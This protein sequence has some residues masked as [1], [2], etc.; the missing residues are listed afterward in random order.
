MTSI[1][2]LP[3]PLPLYI[4]MQLSDLKSLDALRRSSSL[5]AAVFAQHAVELLEQ[6]MLLT[7][8]EGV[9]IR[10][11]GYILLL[12]YRSRWKQTEN[13]TESLYESASTPLP[14]DTPTEAIS[15]AL[16]AFSYLH[17]LWTSIAMEKLAQLY[18]LPHRHSKEVPYL[19]EHYYSADYITYKVPAVS[20]LYWVEEQ[21]GLHALFHF[22]NCA[23]L[24]HTLSASSKP[25]GKF[26]FEHECIQFFAA[27]MTKITRPGAPQPLNWQAPSIKPSQDDDR[28]QVWASDDFSD[29][30]SAT[31]GWRTF[32]RNCCSVRPTPL[33][34]EDWSKFRNLGLG[35]WSWK[36]LSRDLEL[37]NLPAKSRPPRIRGQVSTLR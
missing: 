11:R 31:R 35:L 30:S 22:R 37:V 25:F 17:D 10:I 29:A 33:V 34:T 18:E 32:R 16:R 2:S 13:V 7:L 36:R 21:R 9:I 12:A 6:L 15:L 27:Y 3:A 4:A 5:F 8:H 28:D 1:H 20:P 23:L 24:D 14:K 19:I 26:S